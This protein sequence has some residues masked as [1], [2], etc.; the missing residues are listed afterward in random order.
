MDLKSCYILST[1]DK[2]KVFFYYL[3]DI[4]NIVL[5]LYAA[6]RWFKNIR[7]S[8][9][10]VFPLSKWKLELYK[11][12]LCEKS[13][14]TSKSGNIKF[15]SLVLVVIIKDIKPTEIIIKHYI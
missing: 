10:N 15:T 6:E 4:H 14:Y 7:I 5:H 3:V 2:V 12:I 1:L 9:V 13:S 8:S 11:H